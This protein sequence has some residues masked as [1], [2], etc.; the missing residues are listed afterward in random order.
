MKRAWNE[1]KDLQIWNDDPIKS[2]DWRVG[3]PAYKSPTT[4]EQNQ[5]ITQREML[6]KQAGMSLLDRVRYF[7]LKH[8]I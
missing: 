2:M 8:G 1:V 7:D 5:F 3:R 4:I 6:E